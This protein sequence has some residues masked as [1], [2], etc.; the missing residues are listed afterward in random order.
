M[1]LCPPICLLCLP[2][3][4]LLRLLFNILCLLLRLLLQ[5]C[6]LVIPVLY[7]SYAT[8][9]FWLFFLKHLLL[10]F[11]EL[12]NLC[13]YSCLY[14]YLFSILMFCEESN[15][16]CLCA[17]YLPYFALFFSTVCLLSLVAQAWDFSAVL[18]LD[19]CNHVIFGNSFANLYTFYHSCTQCSTLCN[20]LC[21]YALPVP[22]SLHFP[23]FVSLMLIPFSFPCLPLVN[24]LFGFTLWLLLCILTFI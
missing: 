22:G 10:R 17:I 21:P 12:F 7:H 6:W 5:L 14:F 23:A 3:R 9:Y 13:A 18:A 1:P 2:L 15:L 4:L 8:A 19:C 20:L 11:C 24:N 16:W